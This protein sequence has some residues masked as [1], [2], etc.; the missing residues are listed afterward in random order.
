M[1]IVHRG[2]NAETAILND[3]TNYPYNKL[4]VMG[5][6]FDTKNYDESV[7]DATVAAIDK[8]FDSLKFDEVADSTAS[9]PV[10][11]SSEVA[12][13]ELMAVINMRDRWV[14]KG[15]LTTPTC[16]E[17]L[18]WNF[19]K[20]V[21]PIKPYH[22]AYYKSAMKEHT[23]PN[24]KA[25]EKGNF[26]TARP[27]GSEHDLKLVKGPD[28]AVEVSSED[29][30]SAANAS[31]AMAV[32]M[33]LAMFIALALIIYTCVLHDRLNSPMENQMASDKVDV[34]PGAEEPQVDI[35]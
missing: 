26:R 14:Y 19:V 17:N 1:H 16:L 24:T 29:V 35:L 34:G 13:G 22:L 31:L 32:L 18:Y 4:A 11:Y 6:M 9:P 21:Y 12:L 23:D 2:V 28:P 25:V 3:K 10:A 7:S 30:E 5:I 33:C 20:T 27:A 8:F 15:S